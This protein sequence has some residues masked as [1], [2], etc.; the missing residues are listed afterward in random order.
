M[1]AKAKFF[2][3]VCCLFLMFLDF[4]PLLPVLLGVNRALTFKRNERVS[5][6]CTLTN[7]VRVFGH[8]GYTQKSF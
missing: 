1:E 2:F 7:Y 5:F 6:S 8:E 4:L 3:K